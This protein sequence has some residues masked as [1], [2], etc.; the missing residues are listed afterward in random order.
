MGGVPVILWLV[1]SSIEFIQIICKMQQINFR[2]SD[3]IDAHPE[4]QSDLLV[5]F[6]RKAVHQTP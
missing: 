4:M 2:K 5:R 6:S 1:R 3:I